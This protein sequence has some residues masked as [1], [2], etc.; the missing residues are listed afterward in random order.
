MIA[1]MFRCIL[2]LEMEG[3]SRSI[4]RCTYGRTGVECYGNRSVLASRHSSADSGRKTPLTKYLESEKSLLTLCYL[5]LP[6]RSS[7]LDFLHSNFHNDKT[8]TALPL[9]RSYS[10]PPFLSSAPL[11]LH[12]ATSAKVAELEKQGDETGIGNWGH[13][14]LQHKHTVRRGTSVSVS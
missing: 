14:L 13:L 10:H 4:E 7:L 3:P 2:R 5:N 9:P 12:R 6:I 1:R 8:D 11:P